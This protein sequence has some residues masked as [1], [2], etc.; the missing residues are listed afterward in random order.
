MSYTLLYSDSPADTILIGISTDDPTQI[1][2]LTI[3]EGVTSIGSYAFVSLTSLEQLTLPT[4][5]TELQ[6]NA[7]SQLFSLTSLTLP[8]GLQTLGQAVFYNCTS[9]TSIVVPASVSS[10]GPYMFGGCSSLTSV[11]FNNILS[12]TPTETFAQCI[13][14]QSVQYT[15]AA[16]TVGPFAFS[17]VPPSCIVYYTYG[18][19][20]WGPTYGGKKTVALGAPFTGPSSVVVTSADSSLEVGFS[21]ANTNGGYD[22]VDYYVSFAITNT[23]NV[24]T[25]VTVSSP[26]NIT[27]LVNG[28]QYVI[29]VR[30]RNTVSAFSTSSAEV[31]GTPNIPPSPCCSPPSRNVPPPTQ[32]NWLTTRFTERLT[33]TVNTNVGGS[34][35]G[36]VEP[37]QPI[38]IDPQT[39]STGPIKGLPSRPIIVRPLPRSTN[40]NEYGRP[41]RSAASSLL[42]RRIAQNAIIQSPNNKPYAPFRPVIPVCPVIGAA[43]QAGVPRAPNPCYPT[44]QRRVDLS[45]RFK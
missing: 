45:S 37:L 44:G 30:A 14:L 16:P 19:P 35:C 38:H 10:F 23:T 1:I 8:S 13:T 20:G 9:I 6:A 29:T 3:P 24:Q 7:L 33:A 22:I 28:V 36:A 26:V 21:G 2:N 41:M 5:L 4:T 11:V 31:S 43:P 17:A 42:T 18:Q 12:S 39:C 25:V 32:H 34:V 40:I 15:G 27:G